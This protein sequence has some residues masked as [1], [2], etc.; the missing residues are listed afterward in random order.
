MSVNA[1]VWYNNVIVV[2]MDGQVSSVTER[3]RVYGWLD[4]DDNAASAASVPDDG[5]LQCTAG[6]L[7]TSK[8]S[9]TVG[10][11]S[12]QVA[13]KLRSESH[14]HEAYD[15]YRYALAIFEHHPETG[16]STTCFSRPFI[17]R[18][19]HLPGEIKSL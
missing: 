8:L 5:Q 7:S 9:Q 1:Y 16:L 11:L 10:H 6:L 13:N 3:D 14:L 18:R 2:D 15:A 19:P 17:R 4:A 12:L